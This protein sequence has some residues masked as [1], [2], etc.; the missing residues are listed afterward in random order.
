MYFIVL[1]VRILKFWDNIKRSMLIYIEQYYGHEDL[2]FY[3]IVKTHST[4]RQNEKT[5]IVLVVAAFL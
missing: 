2:S 5:L 4:W 1:V 3:C